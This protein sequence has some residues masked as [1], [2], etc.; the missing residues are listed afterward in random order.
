VAKVYERMASLRSNFS[1]PLARL[2][3]YPAL[4]LEN[5]IIPGLTKTKLAKSM[6]DAA[7]R[8]VPEPRRHN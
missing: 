4:C 3:E 6:L 5:L 1:H 2:I 8:Q 7:S